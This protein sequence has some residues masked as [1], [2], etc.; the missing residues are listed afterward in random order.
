MVA[1]PSLDSI[2]LSEILPAPN[3]EREPVAFYQFDEE[4]D[5][6]NSGERLIVDSC[7]I[8]CEWREHTLRDD[9]SR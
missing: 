7:S 8:D 3:E 4:T 1:R 5:N 6:F 2:P 9:D